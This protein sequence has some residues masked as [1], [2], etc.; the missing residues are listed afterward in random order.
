MLTR[1]YNIDGHV[2]TVDS[3]GRRRDFWRIDFD[4]VYL[5]QYHS[6]ET[7]ITALTVRKIDSERAR[8]IIGMVL[9]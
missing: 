3:I 7:A 5:G 1:T 4:G 2:I 6:T 8:H 9:L